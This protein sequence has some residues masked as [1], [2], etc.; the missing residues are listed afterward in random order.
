MGNGI[1]LSTNFDLGS[2]LPL[3]SRMVVSNFID[4]NNIENKYQGLTCYV[5]TEKNLYVYQGVSWEKVVTNNVDNPPFI[6]SSNFNIGQS[7]NGQVLYVNNNTPTTGTLTG[8]FEDGFNISFV[9]MGSGSIMFSG[10]SVGT[11]RNKIGASK[12]DGQY[13]IASILKIGNTTDF[14]LYGDVIN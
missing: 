13:A 5:S 1:Q 3:D 11:L 10:G 8:S 7:Y 12:T 14:L 4:L 6:T 2:P 9:Q